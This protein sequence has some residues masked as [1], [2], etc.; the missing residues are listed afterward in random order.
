MFGIIGAHVKKETSRC[1]FSIVITI[2]FSQNPQ[3]R[4]RENGNCLCT[5]LLPF[6][7]LELSYPALFI[8]SAVSF[9]Y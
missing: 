9:L 2:I 1:R 6:L 7:S 4:D 3:G 8:N 5:V